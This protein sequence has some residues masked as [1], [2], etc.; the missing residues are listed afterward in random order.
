M[1]SCSK[2]PKNGESRKM[3]CNDIITY[4]HI[5]GAGVALAWLQLS[6]AAN[7]NLRNASNA[8]G[9]AKESQRLGKEDVDL[10]L[11]QGTKSICSLLIGPVKSLRPTCAAAVFVQLV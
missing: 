4:S 9:H 10:V 5:G 8:A 2:D 6:L 11:P 1:C 7:K 3:S